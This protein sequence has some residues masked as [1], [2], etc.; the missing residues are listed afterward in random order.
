MGLKKYIGFSLILIIAVGLYVY[1][2]EN[3]DYRLTFFDISFLLPTVIWILVP[4][5]VLFLFS[6]LHLLFYGSINYCK[7]RSYIKDEAAILEVLKATLLQKRDKKRLKTP[8]FKNLAQIL[9]Q[10]KVDVTD[11]T[12]TSTNKELNETVSKIKDIKSGKYVSSLK[13]DQDSLLAKQN[14]KNKM[15]E[16]PDY[17]L[18]ILKKADQYSQ[19]IV[20]FA[21]DSVLENKTMTTIK[22]V[23]N[24]VNLDREK[25]YK[26]FLKD[27]ENIEFGLSKDEIIKI[28]K[29]LSYTKEEFISLARLYKDSYAPDQLLDLF[30]SLSNENDEAMSAY[31]YVLCE[32]EMI[33]K[34]R[35]LLSAYDQNEMLPFKAILDLKD[36]G[37]HY[38]LDQISI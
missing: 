4:L 29:S 18:D 14:L 21:F 10:F 31:F 30:E 3:G 1:T 27:I 22:K 33:D 32:L 15:S 5:I 25:A 7:N 17:S 24:N 12:F 37:K 6:V 26:L 11:E 34:L 13:L 20:D 35:D 2:I 9:D 28:T 38:S 36:S 19:D 8:G 23:Y 16:Q